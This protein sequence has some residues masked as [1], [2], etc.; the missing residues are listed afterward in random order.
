MTDRPVMADHHDLARG[1]LDPAHYDYFAG[2]AGTERAVAANEEA[3]ARKALLP[4]VLRGTAHPDTTVVLPGTRLAV[5]VFVAPTA[6]HRLAHPDGEAATARAAAAE[7]MVLVT[8]VAAT[9]P[10]AGVVAAASEV[11]PAAAVW[12]QLY[13]QREE[14]VSEALV[15]RA[16]DAGCA[17]LVVTVDSPVFGRHTRDLRNGFTDLPPGYAAENMRDLPGAPP[18][19]PLGIAMAPAT[20]D[21]LDRLRAS[22][23]LPVLLKGVLHPDDARLAVRHGAAG[24]IVSNHGGRQLDAAPSTLAALPGV[25]EAVA[26]AVPVLLDGGVRRGSDVAIAV[27]LGAAAVGVGRPVLWGLAADGEAGVRRVLAG[28]RDEYEH[29]LTLAGAACN[30]DLTPDMVVDR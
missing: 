14:K 4:R 5:P 6:F 15:R 25:V 10:V 2:G 16:E 30:H 22:T 11:D 27:A 26:G 7:G 13:P 23:T 8:G 1:K 19:E 3:F 20:W 29:T 18:G 17:A 9:T 24:I 28:L 12:F 21:D